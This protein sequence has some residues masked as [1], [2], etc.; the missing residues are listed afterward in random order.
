MACNCTDSP[1]ATLVT[2]TEFQAMVRDMLLPDGTQFRIQLESMIHRDTTLW[3]CKL[4]LHESQNGD[5]RRALTG[6]YTFSG[7]VFTGAAEQSPEGW[8]A[9]KLTNVNTSPFEQLKVRARYN[10]S[11]I[12]NDKQLYDLELEATATVDGIQQTAK[13]IVRGVS[14]PFD[15]FATVAASAATQSAA[16]YCWERQCRS[17]KSSANSSLQVCYRRLVETSGQ[18]KRCGCWE[19]D[20]ER[21]CSNCVS[22][23]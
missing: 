6:L 1:P 15:L 17:M 11:I 16:K 23:C 9:L 7:P 21:G 2:S 18:V 14:N 19:K 13:E 3:N 10:R 4:Q 22:S 5:L 8:F 20:P 12:E